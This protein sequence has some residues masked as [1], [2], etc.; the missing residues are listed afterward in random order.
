MKKNILAICT[1]GGILVA[2]WGVALAQPFLWT[3]WGMAVGSSIVLP[4]VFGG[5]YLGIYLDDKWNP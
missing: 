2:C 3:R 4:A 5:I 1:V